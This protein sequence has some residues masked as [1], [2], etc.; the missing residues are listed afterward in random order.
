M[1]MMIRTWVTDKIK[2]TQLTPSTIAG[3]RQIFQKKLFIFI[4]KTSQELKKKKVYEK[5][6]GRQK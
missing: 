3:A 1:M 4:R 2:R 6:A 5:F